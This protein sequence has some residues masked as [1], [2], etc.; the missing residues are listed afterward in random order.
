MPTN[1]IGAHAFG[2]RRVL[3]SRSR[4]RG[5]NSPAGLPQK[6]LFGAECS[7]SIAGIEE[8]AERPTAPARRAGGV[9][10]DDLPNQPF[11]QQIL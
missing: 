10:Q 11:N 7:A 2:R 1:V 8:A 9:R 3:A 5:G 4:S 6:N